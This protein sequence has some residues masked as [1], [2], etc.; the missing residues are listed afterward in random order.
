MAVTPRILSRAYWKWWIGVPLL[1]LSVAG[2]GWVYANAVRARD[3][4]D[5]ARAREEGRPIPVRTS[6]VTE[7]GAEQVIGGTA[8]TVASETAFV[9]VA[10]LRSRAQDPVSEVVIKAVH[11]KDGDYVKRGQLLFEVDDIVLR[12][13]LGQREAELAAAEAVLKAR[14]EDIAHQE[15]LL[16]MARKLHA[17]GL[18]PQAQLL[19][20]ESR[21]LTVQSAFN[22]ANARVNLLRSDTTVARRDIGRLRISSPLEG[23]ITAVVVVPG[24]VITEPTVLAKVLK[25]D[26]L[27]V[28]MDFPQEHLRSVFVG[29]E[30]DTVLDSFPQESFSGKV[31]QIMPEVKRDL[32]VLPVLIEIR[33]PSHRLKA[34]ISGFTRL[35][36]GNRKATGVPTT[37]LIEQDGKAMV[38]RVEDG[39]ARLRHVRVGA[40]LENGWR[41]VF[42]G[43]MPGDEV[44][45]FTNFY[46]DVGKLTLKNSY[47]QDNDAVDVD[48][49][50]WTRRQ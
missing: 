7:M 41:E 32:R 1:A 15:K 9:Q 3:L 47:L 11:V 8:A 31:V 16:A 40:V 26:P 14:R 6:P 4:S 2:V 25:L 43:L 24:T 37:A 38:F 22:E 19:E 50:K 48:W 20:A 44:V 18:T 46:R 35:R 17:E 23:F 21:V 49:R 12:Q 42:E 13:V 10:P 30:A 36:V 28:M 39:R 27:N 5:P 29:Q 33:N 45:I 34:G